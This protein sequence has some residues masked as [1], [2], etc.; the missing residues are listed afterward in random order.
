[1]PSI[2]TIWE[3]Q[4]KGMR[5]EKKL[6]VQTEQVE[7]LVAA[8]FPEYR[9]L[10][11][12]P[13]EFDGWDNCTFRLGDDFSVRLPSASYYVEQINKEYTW[14]PVLAPQLP[15]PI[16]VPVRTGKP[17]EGYPFP[18]AIN[19]WM[20]GE[21]ATLNNITGMEEFASDLAGFLNALRKVDATGGPASGIQNF[22]RGSGLQVYNTDVDQSL[23]S[24]D[25]VLDI[26]VCARV[27]A[28]ALASTWEQEPVWVHGDVA[29]GNLLVREGRLTG[30][31][32]FGVCC[33]G[34][35]ACDLVIAWTFLT[36]ASRE[37]FCRAIDVDTAIWDRAK[38]WALWKALITLESQVKKQAIDPVQ[39]A[40]VVD[41]I[42][43]G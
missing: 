32:D 6:Y 8:Q 21:T 29:A 1:M 11:I 19:R 4:K 16:T 35:P 36:G 25:G 38:G 15:L 24:L 39:V 40:L 43:E 9:D 18:W 20:E 37:V 17:G 12:R 3:A 13:V 33:V 7:R 10:T 42:K 5:A 31:I 30:V 34:D 22:Y 27:W 28:A 41:L 14:L 2:E 26:A 23:E